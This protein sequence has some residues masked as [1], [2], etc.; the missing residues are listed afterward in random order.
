[1]PEFQRRRDTY[2]VSIA[3]SVTIENAIGGSGNDNIGNAAD[4]TIKVAAVM[5]PST[6][7]AVTTR[8]L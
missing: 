7:A 2:N 6:V 4:N 3:Q 1:M 8:Q 5:M